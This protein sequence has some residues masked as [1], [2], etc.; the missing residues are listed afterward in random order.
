MNSYLI[1]PTATGFKF[2]LKAANGQII[3]TSEVYRNTAACRK[4]IAS[5]AACA[6]AAPVEDQTGP[7]PKVLPHPKFELFAD[8]AGQY[9]FRLKA[10]NG[11]IIAVSEGYAT[12]AGCEKGIESVRAHAADATV[13]E[14]QA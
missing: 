13:E 5:V 2:D 14:A 9:R 11:K 4:G 7:D 10:R 3:A 8:K 12:H 1:R 6:P